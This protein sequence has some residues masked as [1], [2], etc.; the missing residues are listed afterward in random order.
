[1]YKGKFV[2]ELAMNDV[3]EYYDKLRQKC[4]R[5]E[6]QWEDFNI[7][8]EKLIV[9]AYKILDGKTNGDVIKAVFGAKDVDE[10]F[11]TQNITVTMSGAR[12]TFGRDWWY[13]PYKAESGVQNGNS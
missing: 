6:E 5:T 10:N 7:L 2:S 4:P 9:F 3:K 1:M 13:S 8:Q 11:V 12:K